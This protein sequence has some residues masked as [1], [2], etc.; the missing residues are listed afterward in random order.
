ML[1]GGMKT[2]HSVLQLKC[3]KIDAKP[4]SNDKKI[5]K[6]KQEKTVQ[7]FCQSCAR[8]VK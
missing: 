6:Y 1:A 2:K 4:P 8:A 3:C 7:T 5:A